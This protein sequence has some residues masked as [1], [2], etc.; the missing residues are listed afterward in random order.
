MTRIWRKN[1]G[2]N[3]FLKFD[4]TKKMHFDK[5]QILSVSIRLNQSFPR[6]TKLYRVQSKTQQ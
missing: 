5:T 3:Y 6:A 4:E 2:F 1:H